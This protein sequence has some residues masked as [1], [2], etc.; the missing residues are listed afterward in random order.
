MSRKILKLLIEDRPEDVAQINQKI[1][2]V[3]KLTKEKGVY[4]QESEDDES[5]GILNMRQA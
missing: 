2:L 5:V 4:K 1:K 3:F